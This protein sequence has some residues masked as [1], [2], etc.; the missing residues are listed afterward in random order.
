M[1]FADVLDIASISSVVVVLD[2]ACNGGVCSCISSVVVVLDIVCNGG[3]CGC[4]RYSL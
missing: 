1:L 3:V 4:I 2:I